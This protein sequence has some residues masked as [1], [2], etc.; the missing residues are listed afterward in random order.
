MSFLPMVVIISEDHL[1][2]FEGQIITQSC[3]EETQSC[4]KKYQ[5][6]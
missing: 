6:N 3:T 1:I 2:F 4:T 5:A